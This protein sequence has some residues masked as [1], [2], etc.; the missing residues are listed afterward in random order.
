MSA[1]DRSLDDEIESAVEDLKIALGRRRFGSVLGR[2]AALQRLCRAQQLRLELSV[3][4]AARNGR[5]R[6]A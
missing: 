5:R 4:R 3:D 1:R 6:A 2:L